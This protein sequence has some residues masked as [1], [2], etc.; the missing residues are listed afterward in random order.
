V[1]KG[2]CVRACVRACTCVPRASQRASEEATKRAERAKE[3][4]PRAS[5]LPQRRACSRAERTSRSLHASSF[6]PRPRSRAASSVPK[7][8]CHQRRT[9]AVRN[10]AKERSASH[11]TCRA[12]A[13]RARIFV[14]G[15]AD[16]S[17]TDT[18]RAP[19][20]RDAEVIAGKPRCARA[21][22]RTGGIGDGMIRGRRSPC[23]HIVIRVR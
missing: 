10:R 20:F 6:T 4:V 13:L 14:D 8:A 22:P 17:F 21:T 15:H 3:N 12:V 7:R 5:G 16:D 9:L 1:E 19:R 2:M 23:R 18:F 11:A